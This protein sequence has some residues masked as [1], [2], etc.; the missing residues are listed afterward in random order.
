MVPETVIAEQDGAPVG[1][2]RAQ[3]F[4]RDGYVRHLVVEPAL[5]RRGAGRAM[6]E[7]VRASM[8]SAGCERWRLNVKP[9]N[10][11][12]VR[13]YTSLG[14]KAQHE[15]ASVRFEWELLDALP[16]PSG[17]LSVAEPNATQRRTLESTY[18]LPMG[19][20]ATTDAR[21]DV[22]VRAV[23]RGA[24][25]HGVALFDAAFP[26][27]FPFRTASVDA[28]MTL[29]HGL[30]P[31]ATQPTMGIVVEDD[32]ALDRLMADAGARVPFRFVHMRG[33]L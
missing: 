6:L 13:L 11:P 21:D 16:Q 9:D 17:S 10:V 18:G 32:H 2:C 19:Q 20:L 30:R 25:L 23:V 27:A 31:L 1:Y 29:L 33:R 14:M 7:R 15:C 22:H 26:G 28:A 12:A 24:D 8:R 5:R 4:G 3:V